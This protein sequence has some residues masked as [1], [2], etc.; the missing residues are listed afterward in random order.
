MICF[1]IDFRQPCPSKTCMSKIAFFKLAF[2][3]CFFQN[4]FFKM[5]FLK[6]AFSKW[7]FQNGF[8]QNGF[9]IMAFPKWLF[10][11][12]FFKMAFEN[13]KSCQINH[14]TYKG[15]LILKANSQAIILPKNEGINSFLLLCNMF[16]FIFWKKLKTHKRHFK[17]N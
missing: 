5:A 14:A 10:Q 17:I 16:L 7:L 11:N 4:G 8:F 1:A 12:G 13:G 15:Q 2:S 6:M 3:K 9:S